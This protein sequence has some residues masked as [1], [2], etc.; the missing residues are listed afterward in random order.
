MKGLIIKDYYMLM[1]YFKS[2]IDRRNNCIGF[3]DYY[4][5]NYVYF[6]FSNEDSISVYRF[7]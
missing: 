7:R 1:K 6:G 3:Y 2:Y 4:F 5:S